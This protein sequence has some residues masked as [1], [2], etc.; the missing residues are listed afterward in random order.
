MRQ[1][2]FGP[3]S[4]AIIAGI[5]ALAAWCASALTD[6][7]IT[8]AEWAGLLVALLTPAATYQVTNEPEI[9]K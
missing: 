6:G 4:K 7:V 9:K 5:G 2:T 8:P 3:Y 1:I